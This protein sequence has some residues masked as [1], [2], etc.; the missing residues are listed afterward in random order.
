[1]ESVRYRREAKQQHRMR[2]R[3]AWEMTERHQS[4]VTRTE[5][6]INE[7]HSAGPGETDGWGGAELQRVSFP[8]MKIH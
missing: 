7:L 2:N 5:T 6:L 1:M 3:A 4:F 8:P